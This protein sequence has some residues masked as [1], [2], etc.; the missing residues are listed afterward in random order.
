MKPRHLFTLALA[1]LLAYMLGAG[2]TQNFGSFKS[3]AF[4]EKVC[5]E[6]CVKVSDPAFG[7]AAEGCTACDLPNATAACSGT[8]CDVGGCAAGFQSCDGDA[9]NGC[10]ISVMTDP[11]HCG[12]CGNACVV[13]HATPGCDAGACS[14]GTC[15]LGF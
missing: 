11:A 9:S 5:G 7:C 10:E 13:P 15:D 2:C 3:C 12:M 4:D 14:V 1:A 6:G 8:V